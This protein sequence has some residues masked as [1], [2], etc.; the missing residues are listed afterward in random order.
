[1]K[2][3]LVLGRTAAMCNE[4]T[5]ILGKHGFRVAPVFNAKKA[6]HVARILPFD[7]IVTCTTRNPDDRRSLTGEIKHYAP[8]AFIVLLSDQA[9]DTERAAD[10]GV[11]QILPLPVT[12]Q[13]LARALDAVSAGHWRPPAMRPFTAERRH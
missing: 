6:L 7:L 8:D 11:D 1:M 9:G 3:A 13:A 2:H 10:D 5:D 12:R 4:I